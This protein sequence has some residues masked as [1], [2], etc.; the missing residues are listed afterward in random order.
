MEEFLLRGLARCCC[1]ERTWQQRGLWIMKHMW[2]CAEREERHAWRGMTGWAASWAGG[3]W[4]CEFP[5][6]NKNDRGGLRGETTALVLGF[7]SLL[8]GTGGGPGN[9][10]WKRIQKKGEEM[11]VYLCC[12]LK[13]RLFLIH[14]TQVAERSP[15][16]LCKTR[17][18]SPPFLTC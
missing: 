5:K 16:L 14:L 2:P 3:G 18:T 10:T 7:E 11:R 1:D 6:T 9:C 8:T 12:C 17:V 15:Q 13:T 4:K